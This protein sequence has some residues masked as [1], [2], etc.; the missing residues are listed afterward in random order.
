MI[1]PLLFSPCHGYGR[2]ADAVVAALGGMCEHRLP[3]GHLCRKPGQR[4]ADLLTP[5][6]ITRIVD[7]VT[8]NR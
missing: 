4:P 3:P 6:E 5:A 8:A 1:A 7:A 2:V